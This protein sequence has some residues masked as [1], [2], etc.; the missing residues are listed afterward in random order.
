MFWGNVLWECSVG[1]NVLWE[2]SVGG[3]VLWECSVGMFCGNV[4]R[5]G[6]LFIVASVL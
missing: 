5:V 1:G 2:C 4:L 6:M 3:N